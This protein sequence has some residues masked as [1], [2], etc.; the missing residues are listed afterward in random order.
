MD[1]K[2]LEGYRREIRAQL[3]SCIDFWLKNG[4]D[5]ECGGVLTCL[6]RRGE[7]FSG[8]KSV[9]MQ[10]RCAWTFARL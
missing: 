5:A 10:G 3:G 1:R 7:V 2:R 8:D 6:D 9:W 4:M